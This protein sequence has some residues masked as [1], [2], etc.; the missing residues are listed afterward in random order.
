MLDY[1]KSKSK[2]WGFVK[3]TGTDEIKFHKINDYTGHNVFGGR[4]KSRV[5]SS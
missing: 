3:T 5:A 1:V 4:A 2:K